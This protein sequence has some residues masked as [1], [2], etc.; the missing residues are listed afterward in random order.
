MGKRA[1]LWDGIEE[2]KETRG[3]FPRGH[4]LI[5]AQDRVGRS[6]FQMIANGGIFNVNHGM[7]DTRRSIAHN[8][9]A[10]CFVSLHVPYSIKS[11]IL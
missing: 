10:E 9:Q 11:P 7:P 6:C 3:A 1:G 8:F 4:A 5:V 2:T